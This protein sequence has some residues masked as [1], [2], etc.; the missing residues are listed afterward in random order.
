MGE[1]YFMGVPPGHTAG[2]ACAPK[3]GETSPWGTGPWPVLDW[4]PDRDGPRRTEPPMPTVRIGWNQQPEGEF[5]WL[6]ADGWT[7]IAAWDRSADTRG[8]CTASF[9]IHALVEPDA[10]LDL[11]RA[12]HPAVLAR[13][14][15]HIGRPVTVRPWRHEDYDSALPYRFRNEVTRG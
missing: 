2:H 11:A 6:Q 10:M 1:V 5:V 13:I 7:L 9:A 4:H 14:E 8:G 3:V 15:A 12:A